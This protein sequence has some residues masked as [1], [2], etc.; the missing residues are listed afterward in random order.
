MHSYIELKVD[1]P[2][3]PSNPKESPETIDF[4]C[5]YVSG[6][7][8]IILCI[9][10]HIYSSTECVFLTTMGLCYACYSPLL[11]CAMYFEEFSISVHNIFLMTTGNCCTHN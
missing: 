3:L 8:A 5:L 9:T 1:L 11:S 2:F 4:N 10:V 6:H 7:F